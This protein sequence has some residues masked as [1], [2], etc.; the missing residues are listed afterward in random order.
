MKNKNKNRETKKVEYNIR[1]FN[2][3]L[4]AKQHY[5]V[6]MRDVVEFLDQL[7]KLDVDIA[8][9]KSLFAETGLALIQE[10]EQESGKESKI[11]TIN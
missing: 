1:L 2:D 3:T 10:I 11:I 7:E 9:A 4:E 8:E 6:V 5:T